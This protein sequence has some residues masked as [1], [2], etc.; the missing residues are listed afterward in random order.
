MG[1]STSVHV[2][3]YLVCT[4][5]QVPV[6]E[7]TA[8][9]SHDSSHQ[10]TE[11]HAFCPT[12]GH[13]VEQRTVQTMEDQSLLD[14]FHDV[15]KAPVVD[16]LF[17]NSAFTPLIDECIGFDQPGCEVILYNNGSESISADEEGIHELGRAAGLINQA[18]PSQEE[19]E[20]L[21]SIVGYTNV[22]VKYG[23]LIEVS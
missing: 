12:C 3:C 23:V 21:M 11:S 6:E 20:R 15:T 5:S 1:L 18:R 2:G 7:V 14:F 10:V 17:L 22:E 8:T 16:L 19:I 13:P 9:C 4:M